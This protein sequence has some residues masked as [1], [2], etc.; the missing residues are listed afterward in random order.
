MQMDS[1][2]LYVLTVSLQSSHVGSVQAWAQHAT[3][4]LI[5]RV[6][7]ELIPCIHQPLGD[8]GGAQPRSKPCTGAASVT[9][10]QQT[11]C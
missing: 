6:L 8:A 9:P 3:W 10:W 5:L 4:A 7:A 2:V 1:V 11:W